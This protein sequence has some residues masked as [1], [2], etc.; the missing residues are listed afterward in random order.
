[1]QGVD[2]HLLALQ[3]VAMG[4]VFYF[5][6]FSGVDRHLLALQKVAMGI[7]PTSDAGQSADSSRLPPMFQVCQSF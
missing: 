2:R 5:L 7:L 4:I 6:F 3:K 1:L